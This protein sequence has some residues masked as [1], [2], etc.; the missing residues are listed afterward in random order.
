MSKSFGNFITIR[1]VLENNFLEFNGVLADE[2]KENW[3]G[4]SA[5]FSMLQTHYREPLNWTVQ[6]LMQ[7]SSELYRWYE[8][9][10]SK[11]EYDGKQ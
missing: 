9:L 5:R 11:K 4:L 2:M 3:A 8:L 6:R 10:R 7:S 1:S